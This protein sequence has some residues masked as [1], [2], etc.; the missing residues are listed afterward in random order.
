MPDDLTAADLDPLRRWDEHWRVVLAGDDDLAV[1]RLHEA[2]YLDKMKR[3][4]P[5]SRLSDK[6]RAVLP[7]G[8]VSE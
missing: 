2:G 8:R 6:G 1:W 5:L 7:E 3:R 4:T